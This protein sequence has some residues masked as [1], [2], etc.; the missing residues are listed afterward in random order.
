META[1]TV[2]GN[3]DSSNEVLDLAFHAEEGYI[4]VWVAIFVKVPSLDFAL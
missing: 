3:L 2:V 1:R 4:H